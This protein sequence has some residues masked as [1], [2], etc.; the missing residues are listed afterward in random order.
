MTLFFCHVNNYFKASSFTLSCIDILPKQGIVLFFLLFF[1]SSVRSI[2]WKLSLTF[3]IIYIN[4]LEKNNKSVKCV[5]GVGGKKHWLGIWRRK[6]RV[7]GSYLTS[8]LWWW[9]PRLRV[10]SFLF[11]Q[12]L[13]PLFY[14]SFFLLSFLM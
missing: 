4:W 11:L 2:S 13:I 9:T 5:Y 6:H 12:F 3:W 1:V 8:C 10:P 14:S 7:D